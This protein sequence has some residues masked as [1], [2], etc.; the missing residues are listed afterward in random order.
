M[1][2]RS[3]GRSSHMCLESIKKDLNIQATKK[4]TA[5]PTYRWRLSNR[6][7]SAF[8]QVRIISCLWFLRDALIIIGVVSWESL[9]TFPQPLPLYL[10]MKIE[11]RSFSKIVLHPAASWVAILSPSCRL[12]L[13]RNPVPIVNV[14]YQSVGEFANWS[15]PKFLPASS[16]CI[17][18]PLQ[19]L[20][21]ISRQTWLGGVNFGGGG[22]EET[23]FMQ[24]SHICLEIWTQ[25]LLGEYCRSGWLAKTLGEISDKDRTLPN[26]MISS[27]YTGK[28]FSWVPELT[29]QVHWPGIRFSQ[30][31]TFNF[32]MFRN[33][34]KQ[35]RQY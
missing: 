6:S 16:F 9:L 5:K 22:G 32:N 27:I 14:A 2:C 34:T 33:P 20:P 29:H 23:K 30:A 24:P 3:G 21:S 10:D 1:V 19:A 17:L 7:S 8:R 35:S 13:N 18:P 28:V 26:R 12:L 31:V 11:V 4:T 25:S 15:P